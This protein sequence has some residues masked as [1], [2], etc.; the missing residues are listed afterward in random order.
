MVG[1][2]DGVVG[3]GGV[4]AGDTGVVD[5]RRVSVTIR[6]SRSMRS[7]V[8]VARAPFASVMMV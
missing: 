3:G 5:A 8:D 1:V 4:S 2:V 7:T 6:S